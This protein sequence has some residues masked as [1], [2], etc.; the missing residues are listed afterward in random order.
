MRHG[1]TSLSTNIKSNLSLT[2]IFDTSVQKI[3]VCMSKRSLGNTRR[4]V[5]TEGSIE[6]QVVSIPEHCPPVVL[7]CY[8]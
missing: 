6:L 8:F 2:H 3:P 1:F 4:H 7:S 5:D